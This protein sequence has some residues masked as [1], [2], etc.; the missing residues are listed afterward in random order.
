M[1]RPLTQQLTTTVRRH[2]EQR[3]PAVIVQEGETHR[4]CLSTRLGRRLELRRVRFAGSGQ[5]SDCIKVHGYPLPSL[6]PCVKSSS[7]LWER[8]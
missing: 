8:V 4:G 6:L 2:T 7:N 5:R 3:L 1:V